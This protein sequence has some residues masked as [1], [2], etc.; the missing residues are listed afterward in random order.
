MTRE[1]ALI[2]AFAIAAVGGSSVAVAQSVEAP[3]LVNQPA[4]LELPTAAGSAFEPVADATPAATAQ[5]PVEPAAFVAGDAASDT[6]AAGFSDLEEGA[7]DSDAG[8]AAAIADEWLAPDKWT[9]PEQLGSSVQMLLLLS[10]VSLAPA[11]LVMTTSFVRSVVV[12]GLLRQAIGTQQ[13]PPNQVMTALALFLTLA[14]MSPTWKQVY[15]EAI[16]PY[17]EHEIN[18]ETAW[19]RGIAPVRRFMSLQI[20]R[21]G[22]SDDVWLF[23]DHMPGAVTPTSYDEVPLEAL[24]PAFML[25]ELKTA[26][27]IGFQVY[28]PFVILDLVISS[29]L[30]SMGMLMLPPVLVSLP[31]KLLLFVLV[32]GWHLVVGMLLESFAGVV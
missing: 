1:L 18:L 27:L 30:M 7:R 24:V 13:L 14:V 32:D 26:F 4:R 5:A 3:E 19:Q 15:E 23:L 31:F 28:L 11:L 16:A 6:V 9:S 29:V 21:T 10:V 8:S 20:E 25:S 22:N 2:V 12:L 17:S